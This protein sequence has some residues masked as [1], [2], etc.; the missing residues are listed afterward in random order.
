MSPASG[1]QR[2][3]FALPLVPERARAR[4]AGLGLRLLVQLVDLVLDRG[5]P[6]LE[7]GRKCG[8]ALRH[9]PLD[10]GF[11]RIVVSEK[12]VLNILRYMVRS[13]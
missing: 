11:G 6:P 9:R 2:V 13:G 4:G 3:L 5:D 1:L 10:L 7:A 12:K 8:A